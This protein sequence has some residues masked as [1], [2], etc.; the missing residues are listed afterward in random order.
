MHFDVIFSDEADD[1]FESIGQQI[2]NKWGEKEL[3]EF[4]RR[5]YNV[6]E[7]ISNFPLI[8]Q[9]VNKTHVR[10]AFIH[11]NCSMFYVVGEKRIEVLFF[12]DN[13]QDPMFL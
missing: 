8:F 4:R 9:A 13:R 12:W 10:K 11:K 3:K 5:T 6:T 7:I 1:T 2:M